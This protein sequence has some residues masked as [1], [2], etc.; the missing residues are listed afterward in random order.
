MTLAD[1]FRLS[2]ATIRSGIMRTILTIL[3]LAIGVAAVLTVLALGDA[4]EMRVEDEIAKLGVNKIWIRLASDGGTLKEAD[5]RQISEVVQ[6]PAC[7]GTYAMDQVVHGS[8]PA[9]VQIAGFDAAAAEVH[10]PKLLEGRMLNPQEHLSGAAV[11][12]IDE[13]LEE[14]YG[15]EML[16]EY[17]RTGNRR[18]RVI[19]II[20]P[21]TFQ[22]LSGGN[23]M[24]V[25]PLKTVQDTF[26]TSV[27]EI[28]VSVK[29]GQNTSDIAKLAADTLGDERVR[30]DTLEKEIDAAREIV[31]VF[32][33]VLLCVAFVSM[34]SGGIG[35]M[36]IMLLS[37]RERRNEIGV[38]KAIGG[39]SFQVAVLFLFEAAAYAL[40]G[41]GLGVLMGL[42]LIRVCGYLIGLHAA[43]GIAT[44]LPVLFCAALVGL[45]FGV[46]PAL[47]ASSMPPVEALQSN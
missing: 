31:R 28:T 41:G 30:T 29:S 34:L 27:A 24:M 23:G 15:G 3:S 13:V 42:L 32:V 39:T 22:T 10:A 9:L 38:L 43:T 19:G 6:A 5:A 25:L 33:M 8:E 21:L 14:Y 37:V 12:L 18:F 26:G 20:K 16:G 36:N 4:G 40:M 7:A 35:V 45:F 46:V 1:S 17:V 44:I 47:K 2:A 11:C